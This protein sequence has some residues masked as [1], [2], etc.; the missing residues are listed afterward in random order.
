M[1]AKPFKMVES[2]FDSLLLLLMM[3]LKSI[4]RNG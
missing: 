4:T 2:S 1:G 3:K